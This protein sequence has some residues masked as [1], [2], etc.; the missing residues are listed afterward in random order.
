MNKRAKFK[1]CK[2]KKYFK[3]LI[4]IKNRLIKKRCAS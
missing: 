1:I 4:D 3:R 2:R